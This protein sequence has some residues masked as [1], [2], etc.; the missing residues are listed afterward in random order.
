M[1]E[2]ILSV[3]GLR[4]EFKGTVAVRDLSFDVPQ[5]EIVGL[6]GPNGAGK[7]TTILMLLG[8]ITPDAGSITIFDMALERQR[9]EILK[10]MNYA[11]AYQSLPYNVKVAENLRVFAEIYCLAHPRERIEEL[12][13]SFELID[14]RNH[15][16]GSLSSGEQTRLSLCKALLNK[17]R[18]LLLD[19]PTASL[20]PDQANKARQVILKYAQESGA[21][22]INTSHNMI[23]VHELCQRILFMQHGKII[24]EGAAAEIMEKYGS[25]TLEEVFI[26]IAREPEGAGVEPGNAHG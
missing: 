10:Q 16:T 13:E 5:G 24:A 9:I 11:S 17:P 22:I 1:P 12:L 20:D 26:T 14:L 4:K 18:L 19:E 8:L 25:Q 15:S 3:R 2:N 23:D 6:L 7:T 21:T